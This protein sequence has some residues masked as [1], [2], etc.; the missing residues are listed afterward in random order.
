MRFVAEGAKLVQELLRSSLRVIHIYYTAGYE[1]QSLPQDIDVEQI[2]NKEMGRISGLKTSTDVLAIV[3][4]PEHKLN[5]HDFQN[6]LTLCLDDIQDPGNLGTIIRLAHWFGVKS[7][8]CSP[9]TVDAYSP[10]V[11]QATM[12]AIAAVK[13]FSIPL[14]EVLLEAK[15]LGIPV[16]G[17]FLNGESIYT[18]QLPQVGIVVLGNEGKGISGELEQVISLRLTIPSFSQGDVGSES[19]NVSMAAAIVCSEIR[20]GS[21]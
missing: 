3:A 20:R 19:L 8:V 11:V 6:Q 4:I 2:S 1:V 15:E 18:S 9:N 7:I 5:V 16:M 12:G 14:S 21:R 17:T 13:I 10:K